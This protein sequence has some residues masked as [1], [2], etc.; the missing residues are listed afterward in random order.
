[1][2]LHPS[3]VVGKGRYQPRNESYARRLTVCQLMN[4]PIKGAQGSER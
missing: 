2:Q 3:Q 4:V 1:M